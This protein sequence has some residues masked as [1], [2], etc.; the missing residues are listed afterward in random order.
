MLVAALSF[1]SPSGWRMNEMRVSISSGRCNENSASSAVTGLPDENLA[2]RFILKVK[3]LP[4]ADTSQ[5][6]ANTPTILVGSL[7]SKVTSGW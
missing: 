5:L 6:L 4:S 1:E 3:V 2:S 7:M